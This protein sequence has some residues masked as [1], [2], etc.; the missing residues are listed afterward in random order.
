MIGAWYYDPD[1]MR[2]TACVVDARDDA[3]LW[4]CH[5]QTEILAAGFCRHGFVDGFF[6]LSLDGTYQLGALR[7]SRLVYASSLRTSAR[8]IC[9][10]VSLHG[11]VPIG[12]QDGSVVVLNAER[13]IITA[14]TP[15]PQPYSVDNVP[16]VVRLAR[17]PEQDFD[18]Y[19]TTQDGRLMRCEVPYT[20][21]KRLYGKDVV[22]LKPEKV[23][24]PF[25]G[26][27]TDLSITSEG[28]WSI[29]NDETGE[30][31]IKIE[32]ELLT[33]SDFFRLFPED[34]RSAA[35]VKTQEI[36]VY[37][38]VEEPLSE[39]VTLRSTDD[40]DGNDVPCDC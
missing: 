38:R 4:T 30:V 31:L 9:A 33:S 34:G 11:L 3:V 1:M 25:R 24:H 23:A 22:L 37:R 17:N 12:L 8:P 26:P 16:R 5:H 29:K 27:G 15:A 18:L 10:H 6:T 39:A 19:W 35:V 20:Q 40:P 32:E 7:P 2:F 14:R 28:N 36:A 21:T 13:G